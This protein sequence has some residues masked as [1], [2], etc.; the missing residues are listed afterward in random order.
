MN[1]KSNFVLILLASSMSIFILEIIYIKNIKEQ[2]VND[3]K[4]KNDFVKLST[5]PDLAINSN[6]NYIRHRSLANTF[7]IYSNDPELR[8]YS[9]STY[10]ISPST[11]K[12]INK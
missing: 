5:L 3:V 1:K 12:E 6:T 4:Q 2:S 9:K 11:I 7:D 10:S 8:V